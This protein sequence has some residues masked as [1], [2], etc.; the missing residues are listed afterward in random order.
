MLVVG[1][2]A[3]A[4]TTLLAA[5]PALVGATPVPVTVL[6]VLFVVVL[7]AGMGMPL[8]AA[9]PRPAQAGTGRRTTMLV[10]LAGVAAF[11]VGRWLVGG[12]PPT[13]GTAFLVMTSTLAAVAEEAWF[14]RLWF[15]LLAPAGDGIAIAGSTLLF[16]A[17]HVSIYGVWVLPLDLVAGLL[18][19]WQRSA[20]G[21]WLAPAITHVAAN[22]LVVL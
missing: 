16:A 15:G 10:T 9:A 8:P 5:R 21:S 19:G 2:V 3:V 6:A 11:A 18:L 14:R 13:T 22:L 12:H 1:A 20:S 7:V 4:G 17:V